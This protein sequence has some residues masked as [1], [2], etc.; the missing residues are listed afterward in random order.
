[1]KSIFM[2]C[3]ALLSAITYS[4]NSVPNTSFAKIGSITGIIIDKNTQ[5]P[6]PY[7]TVMVKQEGATVQGGITE[8]NGAFFLK[9]LEEGTYQFEVQ[10]I[11]YTSYSK[12]VT[13]SKSD[14]KVDMG[15]ISL[16]EN[17]T[18][19]EGVDVVAERSSIEQKIDRKVVNIGKDLTTQGPTAS[20][21]MNNIPSLNVDQQTGELSM[22]GNSNVRVMVDGKLS[23]VP[24]AQLLKQ[25]PSTSIKKIELIT[26]P[27]AKYNPEGMSGLINIVLYKDANIGFNGNANVGVSYEEEAKFNTS[28]DLNY[29]RGKFN[30]YGNVGTNIGKYVNNGQVERLDDPV[31][32]FDENQI[33][34][35]YFFNNNKSY[36]YKI[37]VDYFLN[38]K[39]TISFFTNQNIFDGKGLGDTDIINFDP[40]VG[41]SEQLFNNVNSNQNE[42]YNFD[43]KRDFDKEGHNIELEVDYSNFTN[44]EDANFNFEGENTQPDYMDFVDTR[45]QQT[46]ANL[47]YVNP[48]NEKGKLE[49]GLEARLFET[50]VDYSSTG[51]TFNS[52]GQLIPI[53][54]TE[55]VYGM[56]IYSAYATYGQNFEKWSY[57]VGARFEDVSVKADTNSVRSFT[58]DYKQLYPSAF[59]TYTPSEKNQFQVSFSRRVDR[60]GLTQVNPIREWSTP[61]IS[62]FGNPSLLPQFTNSYETNYT[63]RLEHGSLTFGLYY[64]TIKDEINRAL[65]V[66]RLDLTKQILTYDNFDD[67]EAYGVEV[68]LNYKPLEWW[69]IN[70]S[71]DLYS[72]TQRGLTE[73][74]APSENPTVDDIIEEE[75]EVDNVAYNFR[76]N[77][78]FNVTKK[79]SLSLFG[80][81]RGENRGIQ[82]NAKA[83][84]FVNT[85]ARYSFA[86]GKGTFSLN[87]NDIFNTMQFR[88]DGERPYEQR[89]A[90]N[91]ESR[92]IYAGL[93]Y[94]FGSGKNRKAQRKNRDSNTKEGGG[95]IM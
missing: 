59:V 77:N 46:I 81:Y 62:S 94:R 91:W 48:I 47:D 55:F 68:S 26:N 67:T 44:D 21:I 5:E 2:L 82:M 86:D 7:A 93:S 1:M 3:M 74:L 6:I 39:N 60:P 71:F 76:L 80:F 29:R 49:L 23:N 78:N 35:F 84:Y 65:Y 57:Q 52:G 79:I 73:I 13:I 9:D 17:V 72:Q 31:T 40:S 15:T 32:N 89:G 41:D 34:D 33:Q 30:M 53:P 22:R 87:F 95:G 38:E 61:Q 45:R 18:E 24:V 27:S 43:Y 58:D 64:R 85:G 54:D 69:S 8:D 4:Q 90:F 12:S 51:F 42:Q 19:L 83:M 20:D 28:L 70:G 63:R 75:V 14:R 36:L 92:T 50:D 16:E 10:F 25:I 56:D 37:G 11:G 88:F 66:D